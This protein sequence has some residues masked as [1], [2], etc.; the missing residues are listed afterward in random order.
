MIRS[1]KKRSQRRQTRTPRG[2][3]IGYRDEPLRFLVRTLA[4]QAA[5]EVFAQ[6]LAMQR[7]AR[8]EVTAQ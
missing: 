3:P 8:P 4:R 6:E 7:Q 5:R 1:R 2:A